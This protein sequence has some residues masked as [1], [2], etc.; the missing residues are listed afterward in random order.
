M[1]YVS[2][3]ETQWQTYDHVAPV[4]TIREDLSDLITIMSPLDTPLLSMLPQTPVYNTYFEWPIDD[5]PTPDATAAVLE[6]VDATFPSTSAVGNDLRFRAGNGT[7]IATKYV[8]VS[9]SQRTMNLAGV[10]DEFAYQIWKKTL[11]MAKQME[12]NLHWG[13]YAAGGDDSPVSARQTEG[14]YT[15]SFHLG[16]EAVANMLVAGKT[17]DLTASTGRQAPY[18]SIYHDPGSATD[19]TRAILHN[20]LLTPAWRN[21]MQVEGAI[22]LCGAGIKFLV[23]DFALASNGPRNERTIPAEAAKVVDTIDIIRTDF[24]HLYVNLDRYL[25]GPSTRTVTLSKAVTSPNAV[26]HTL[27]K[28]LM[29]F[30]PGMLEIGALRPASFTLLAKIGDAT[31]GMCVFEAGAKCLNPVSI[32]TG[33]DLD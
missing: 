17:Y 4:D 23:A 13:A 12:F 6:G 30:Q 19:L 27:N 21:G 25:D 5:I 18:A 14:F 1:A 26:V 16:V 8:D 3:V 7:V 32:I 33:N 9:D 31:K 2:T 15:Y 24:G 11:E 29:I 22:M 10:E 20:S 28:T